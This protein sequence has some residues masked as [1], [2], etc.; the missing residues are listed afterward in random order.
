MDGITVLMDLSLSK[1]PK[2]VMDRESWCATVHGVAKSQT[3][4]SD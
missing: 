2:L 4:L 3:P 1:V